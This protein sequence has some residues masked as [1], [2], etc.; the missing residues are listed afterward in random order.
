MTSDI[1]KSLP[2]LGGGG[3]ALDVDM[4]RNN[5][6]LRAC[7]GRDVTDL[8]SFVQASDLVQNMTP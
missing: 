6:C 8:S 4:R 7:D 5:D 2:S 3:T 1:Y